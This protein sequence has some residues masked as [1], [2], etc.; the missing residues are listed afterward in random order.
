VIE[1][2]GLYR[3][4]EKINRTYCRTISARLFL[5]RSGLMNTLKSLKKCNTVLLKKIT[6]FTLI[7]KPLLLYPFPLPLNRSSCTHPL[8]FP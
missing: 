3:S 8:K 4:V 7:Q 2:Y 5:S 1:V 6:L